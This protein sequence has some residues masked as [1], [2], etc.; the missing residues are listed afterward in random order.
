V[1]EMSEG[2]EWRRW[3]KEEWKRGEK[4]LFYSIRQGG[5]RK[6]QLGLPRDVVKESQ[7]PWNIIHEAEWHHIPHLFYYVKEK[8]KE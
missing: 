7:V 5:P 4:I 3:V 2:D 1:K 8:L 6:S